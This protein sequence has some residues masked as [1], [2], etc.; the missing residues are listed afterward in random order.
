MK[1]GI[2]GGS[3]DPPH[4]GHLLAVQQILAFTDIE[5]VWFMPAFAHTFAKRLHGVADRLAMTR[6]LKGSSS[7]AHTSVSTIEIDHELDGN[8]IDLV[9]LLRTYH[10]ESLFTFIIGSDQLADFPKWG[11]WERLLKELTFLVVPRGGFPAKPLHEGMTVLEHEHLA[12][13]N[14]SSSMIRDRVAQGM[15]IEYLVPEKVEKYIR[16]HGLYVTR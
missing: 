13:S 4:L 7:G 15:P 16:E 5:H 14:I 6:L 2:L 11:E 3:F 8:T 1:I 10:P 9:P 12:I